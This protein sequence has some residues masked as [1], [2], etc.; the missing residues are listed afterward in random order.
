MGGNPDN[1]HWIEPGRNNWMQGNMKTGEKVASLKKEGSKT[2][3]PVP[4]N[5]LQAAQSPPAK[6]KS[7]NSCTSSSIPS[8]SSIFIFSGPSNIKYSN[9]TNG[10]F[11]N[12]KIL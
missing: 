12:M 6:K 7:V 9:N 3:V 8:V 11:L 2:I 5:K 1:K 10:I 4:I